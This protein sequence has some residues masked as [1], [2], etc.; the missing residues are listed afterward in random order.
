MVRECGGEILKRVLI[1][2]ACN[3]HDVILGHLERC[4][5][6]LV[7]GVVSQIFTK[8]NE[9][10]GKMHVTSVP[11][12]S[13]ERAFFVLWTDS[14]TG[15]E[16]IV[17]GLP[18][19]LY[20]AVV[21]FHLLV[22]PS[23]KLMMGGISRTNVFQI[24]LGEDVSLDRRVG[25]YL[26]I[27][28]TEDCR[29]VIVAKRTT[30]LKSNRA[31][32][33]LGAH[34]MVHLSTYDKSAMKLEKGAVVDC[35][36]ID[37]ENSL[38]CARMMEQMVLQNM[39]TSFRHMFVSVGI[40][41]IGETAK[42][43]V[44]KLTPMICNMFQGSARWTLK[45]KD[46]ASQLMVALKHWTNRRYAKQVIFTVGTGWKENVNVLKV[47]KSIVDRELSQVVKNINKGKAAAG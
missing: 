30:S 39:M 7:S 35:V 17:F 5:M 14:K 8:P 13:N 22:K 24:E 19:S 45:N 46:S 26:P 41:T 38:Q 29:G 36:L 37:Q 12:L 33:L 44:S 20:S 32:C 43:N 21:A 28:F 9:L 15:K 40:I 27:H 1:E 18:G 47:T 42:Q 3:I 10:F 2:D 25:D 34:G 4:D 6:L 16:K 11:I 31:F 23:L